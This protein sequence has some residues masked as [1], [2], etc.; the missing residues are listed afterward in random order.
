M[1]NVKAENFLARI[2]SIG[3]PVISIFLVDGTVTDPVNAPKLFMLGMISF[4]SFAVFGLLQPWTVL[5]NHVLPAALIAV[6]MVFSLVTLLSS[7]SPFSQ[8]FYGVYGRNNGFLT[9]LLLSTLF[10]A[11]TALKQV[12]SYRNLCFG[13]LAAGL[14]N[15][16]Y[17]GWALVFGDILSWNNPYG[18]ILGTFG[19]PNFIGSFLGICLGVLFTFALSPTFSVRTRL[20]LLIPI[21][22]LLVE[23]YLSRAIQGRV[24]SALGFGVVILFWLKFNSNR[25]V[26]STYSIIATGLAGLALAGALQV[27]PLTSVIYKTSVSLRGQY[28]LSGWNTGNANPWNG[29]GFDSL[30]DWYR[31]MRDIR[32]LELPGVDTVVNT[33]H[34]VP[35]DIFAFGGWP[36]FITYLLIFGVVGAKSLIFAIRLQNYDSIFISLFVAWLCYQLQS[37]ISINQIGLAVWGWVLSGALL[38]YMRAFPITGTTEENKSQG[39]GKIS[40]VQQFVSPQLAAGVAIV[41]GGLVSV[42]PLAG[43]M[44][45]RS[46]QVSGELTELENSMRKSYLNPLHSYKYLINV[47]ILEE[48]NFNDLAHKYALEAVEYNPDYFDAWK[49]LSLLKNTSAEEKQIALANMRRLDPKNPEIG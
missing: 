13:L 45:W 19:N 36:L 38:G 15:L 21:P 8:S 1:W 44:K 47:Q 3:V 6:F 39:K 42:P 49:L 30:G 26:L 46:A 10:L 31:R 24:L 40:G 41:I 11:T 27:G 33:A 22:I 7:T 4:A 14:V 12:R 32:A 23:I 48:S 17:C 43:D 35:L 37:L 2:L 28:W 5:R 29:A 16:I 34:N 9:Y 18:N 20:L 25:F